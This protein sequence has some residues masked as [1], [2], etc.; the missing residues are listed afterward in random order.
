MKA[1]D[2]HCLDHKLCLVSLSE[3]SSVYQASVVVQ[4]G[5]CLTWSESQ[6]TNFLMMRLT[7][8]RKKTNDQIMTIDSIIYNSMLPL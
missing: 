8:M 1:F 3:I 7:D 4:P 5:L 2:F 6:K